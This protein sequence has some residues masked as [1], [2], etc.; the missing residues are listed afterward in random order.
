MVL[1]TPLVEDH[2]EF[3]KEPS[4]KNFSLQTLA[5]SVNA[6]PKRGEQE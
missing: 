4:L 2:E 5:D 6:L 3:L 1:W